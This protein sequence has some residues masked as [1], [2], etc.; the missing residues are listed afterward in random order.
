[1]YCK[2][3][4]LMDVKMVSSKEEEKG[5]DQDRSRPMIIIG[6]HV[7]LELDAVYVDDGRVALYGLRS[8][9]R[10]HD[11]GLWYCKE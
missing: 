6:S 1:M 2:T 3:A 4:S 7:T 9:W 8:G 11:G 5:L 10:W